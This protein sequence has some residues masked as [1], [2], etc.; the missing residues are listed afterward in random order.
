ML[1]GS[2]VSICIGAKKSRPLTS[3]S[4]VRAVAGKGLE[5]DRNFKAGKSKAKP[6]QE[7][8]LIEI[9][10]VEEYRRTSG[11][12]FYP[13]DA[14]RN[15]VTRGVSLNE[16]VG[17]EFQVGDVR[18]RGLRLCEPCSH[19]A[20]LTGDKGIIRGMVHRCGLRAQILTDGLIRVGDRVTP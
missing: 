19:L 1:N 17:L 16:L 20:R 3:V 18:V 9:E 4:E 7:L 10:A 8:T 11:K 13:A 15:I 6:D 14:R 2:V 12:E 5:G